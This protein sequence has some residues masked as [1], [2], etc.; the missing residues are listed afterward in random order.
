MPS[1]KILD[2]T[3]RDSNR[4]TSNSPFAAAND[5]SIDFATKDEINAIADEITALRN[6]VSKLMKKMEEDDNE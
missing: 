1:M 3:I 2:Y 4:N 6:K 5:K